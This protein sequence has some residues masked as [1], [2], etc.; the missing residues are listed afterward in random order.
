MKIVADF[1]GILHARHP[2]EM[3]GAYWLFNMFYTQIMLFVAV[4]LGSNTDNQEVEHL[5]LGKDR[6]W[7]VTTCLFL[8]WVFS[9]TILLV[10]CERGFIHTFF[11]LTRAWEYNRAMFDTGDDEY[12]MYI[13]TDHESYFMWYKGEVKEW[14][15]KAWERMHREKKDWFNKV[16]LTSIPL[17]LVPNFEH[18]SVKEEMRSSHHYSQR[19]NDDRTSIRRGDNRAKRLIARMLRITLGTSDVQEDTEVDITEREKR[20][21]SVRKRVLRIAASVRE[22]CEFDADKIDE[23]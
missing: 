23:I 22:E 1:T 4:W 12:R 17:E 7:I 2:Y 10:S 3:G 21:T 14:L 18:E 20:T 16:D 13:F 6:L 19:N 11:Q 8:L 9:L 15:S 5:L